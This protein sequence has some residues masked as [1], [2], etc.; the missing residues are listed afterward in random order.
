MVEHDVRKLMRLGTSSTALILP[1]RWLQDLGLEPGSLVDLFFDG[2]AITVSPRMSAKGGR[3]EVNGMQIFVDLSEDGVG[4]GAQEIVAAYVEG[5]T[6]IRVRG[7]EREISA[8]ISELNNSIAGFIIVSRGRS[9]Y[10]IVISEFPVDPN[11]LVSRSVSIVNEVISAY[12]SRDL[13][14]ADTLIK[15]FRKLYNATL[16]LVRSKAAT[17][18]PE[19]TPKLLDILTVMD[20]MREL[21]TFLKIDGVRMPKVALEDLGELFRAA[22]RSVMENNVRWALKVIQFCQ[23]S[24]CR[25]HASHIVNVIVDLAEVAL[26]KCVRDRACRCKHFFPKVSKASS[27]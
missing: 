5:I 6:R 7:S 25:R 20:K 18:P 27:E 1:K 15:E 4:V 8:L 21:I 22:I 3:S 17:A 12:S 26:R 14:K 11:Q 16:R 24:V 2:S 23:T 19:E 9:L 10:D 13:E